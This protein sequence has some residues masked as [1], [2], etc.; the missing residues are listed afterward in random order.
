VAEKK[1]EDE[2]TLSDDNIFKVIYCPQ[3]GNPYDMGWNMYGRFTNFFDE[4]FFDVAS[5]D[6]IAVS[7]L[8][9]SRI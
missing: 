8:E 6:A 7:K 1:Y 5:K 3:N 2:K 4:G 9:R